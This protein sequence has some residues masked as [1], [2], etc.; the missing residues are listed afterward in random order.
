MQLVMKDVSYIQKD[1]KNSFQGYN[2][3]SEAIIK[4]KMNE[5]FVKHGIV[6]TYSVDSVQV[7]NGVTQKGETNYE[8]VIQCSYTFYD[9]DSGESLTSK[10]VGVGHDKGDKGVYK[11]ITGALKYALTSTFL[12]A[13][14]D[15]AE[16]DGQPPAIQRAEPKPAPSS[17]VPRQV[18]K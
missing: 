16:N 10:S 18:Y 13:T 6:W 7:T 1:K 15:D 12:V 9:V 4:E 17:Y 2:Y 5:A 3:A 8:A 11:A 14:G